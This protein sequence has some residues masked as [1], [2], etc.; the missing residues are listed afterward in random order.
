MAD[1]ELNPVLRRIHHLA[2]L[3]AAA[4]RADRD[5]LGEFV[6]RGDETAF[7]ALVRRHGPLVL[8]VCR[9][10][11]GHEQDAE[12]AFQ[13]TFLVLARNAAA[14]RK[15]E[16]LASWLHGA[17]YRIALRAKR[18]AARRRAREGRARAMPPRN[19]PDLGW[20]EVQTI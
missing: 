11:L 5:L 13:A 9:H 6:A 10:V 15:G 1:T 19:R 20:S 12:D 3:Q 4:S 17:A 8:G 18:D 14:V 7:A 2:G 16:A